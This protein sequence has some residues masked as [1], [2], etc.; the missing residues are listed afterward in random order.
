MINTK[1]ISK[2]YGDSTADYEIL[3]DEAYAEALEEGVVEE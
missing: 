1:R 2:E 3:L